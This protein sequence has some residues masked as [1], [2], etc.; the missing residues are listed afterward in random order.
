MCILPMSHKEG[1]LG[2]HDMLLF[3]KLFTISYLLTHKFGGFRW[4]FELL[5]RDF[6]DSLIDH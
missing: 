6:R 3:M 5:A 2:L 4:F 1:K